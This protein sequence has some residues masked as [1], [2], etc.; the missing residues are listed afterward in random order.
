MGGAVQ[1]VGMIWTCGGVW[2]E[3]GLR[4]IWIGW[5]SAR[6]ETRC[7]GRD[8]GMGGWG[9]CCSLVST[10]TIGFHSALLVSL[11]T[12]LVS[13]GFHMFTML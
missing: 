3:R 13:T 1:E 10:S 5:R 6:N 4:G 8:Y 12:I 2:Y 11:V 7:E 9:G